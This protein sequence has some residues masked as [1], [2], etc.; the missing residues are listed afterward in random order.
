M[1][2]HHLSPLHLQ[3]QSG[4][5]TQKAVCGG[6][7]PLHLILILVWSI[8]YTF[9]NHNLLAHFKDQLTPGGLCTPAFSHAE[10]LKFDGQYFN[11]FENDSL[12]L[13]EWI[14]WHNTEALDLEAE[15]WTPHPSIHSNI[16]PQDSRRVI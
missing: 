13:S 11:K 12:C 7:L 14:Q 5:T 6:W 8:S 15:T 4:Q 1:V 9:R 3:P 2:N 16:K 10:A